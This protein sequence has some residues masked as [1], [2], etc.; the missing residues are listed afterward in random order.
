MKINFTPFATIKT[1]RLILRKLEKKDAAPLAILRS[2]ESVN[3]Y[4]R[5]P[6]TITEEGTAAF[7]ASTLKKIA[8]N[9]LMYWSITLKE[10]DSLIGTVCIWNIVEEQELAE[11]GYELHPD[12]QGKGL[13]TEAI[14]AVINW[15]FNTI[16]LQVIVAL[17]KEENMQS[18]NVLLKNKFQLA[19]NYSETQTKDEDDF[20]VYYLK[21]DNFYK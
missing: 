11:L 8:D 4:I 3:R 5:R 13:V 2:N 21:R 14:N 7:I 16:G 1:E 15:G 10:D 19:T 20:V 18:V 9:V 6:K 12:F 17:V